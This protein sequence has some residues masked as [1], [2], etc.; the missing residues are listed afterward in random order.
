LGLERTTLVRNLK[1]LAGKG[2]I[3]PVPCAGRGLRHRLTAKG[4]ATL[5]QAVPLW[6]SAQER[7]EANLAT[8]PDTA[9]NAMRAL[10]KAAYAVDIGCS[11]QRDD[12]CGS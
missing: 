3:Q 12:P 5:L 10:R 8:D 6:Q 9:R 2:W 1:V 11:G 4:E 7:I